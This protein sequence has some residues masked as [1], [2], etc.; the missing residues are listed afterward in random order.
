MGSPGKISLV[1]AA[2]CLVAAVSGVAPAQNI[3]IDGRFSQAKTLSAVGGN[4]PITPDLGKQVGGNLFHSFGK[5]GLD[6]TEKATFSGP[7][8]TQNVIGRVTGGAQSN[9]NGQIVSAISGANLYLINPSG[10]VFGPTATVNVSGSFYA[11]TA[12][13]LRMSDGAKFQAT[14]P[15]ASTLTMASPAA[16]GFMTATP[17]RIA[18]NGSVLAANGSALGPGTLGLVAGPISISGP[19]PTAAPRANLSAPAG[20]IHV[21]AV[22]STGEVPVNPRNVSAST[23]TSFGPVDIRGGSA[24]DVSDSA[25]RGSGGSVFIRAGALTINAS[26]IN[27][28]NFGSG[29]GG[30]VSLR[31]DS[32]V[33]LSGSTSVHALARSAGRGPDIVITTAGSLTITDSSAVSASTSGSGPGGDVSVTAGTL[34]ITSLTANGSIVSDTTTGAANA[35]NIAIKVSEE[36]ARLCGD[37]RAAIRQRDV[38]RHHHID[39]AALAGAGGGAG[40]LRPTLDS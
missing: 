8:G 40:D 29:A 39:I 14:N 20:T 19:T 17:A 35:G 26:E 11:S 5:F 18:V 30:M 16:F 24:L 22:A 36:L 6:A 12:N 32:Q 13:Y 25:N 33:A 23:V 34:T 27:A 31:G 28:D 9:I 38:R 4:Y 7:S 21:T 10:I 1:L 37:L 15:D 3:S 2:A